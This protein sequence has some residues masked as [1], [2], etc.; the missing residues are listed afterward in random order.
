MKVFTLR[1]QSYFPIRQS[2]LNAPTAIHQYRHLLSIST[3]SY[4]KYPSSSSLPSINSRTTP[5][6]TQSIR[7]RKQTG[8]GDKPTDLDLESYSEVS[9]HQPK[10]ELLEVSSGGLSR[11]VILGAFSLGLAMFIA[12]MDDQKALALG[13]EGPLMEEFWDNMRRYALYILTVSTGAIYT[14]FQPILELLKNPISAFLI[15]TIVAG[16]FYI[17]SQVLSAMVGVS[18][19]TYDYG[20]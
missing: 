9:A 6:P 16:S 10:H 13:P 7:Y 18:D 20:Y 15:I 17:V 1:T 11:F 5:L 14:I 12:G 2:N 4:S 19:F 3:I 8:Y